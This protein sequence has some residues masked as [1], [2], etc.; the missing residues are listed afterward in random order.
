MVSEAFECQVIRWRGPSSP[1]TG[2]TRSCIRW[3]GLCKCTLAFR[4]KG[5][6]I[7][8]EF[9]SQLCLEK[10]LAILCIK[11]SL[12]AN[13]IWRISCQ[14]CVS[15]LLVD[16]HYFSRHLAFS[17]GGRYQ[18][19]LVDRNPRMLCS[20]L[21]VV[22]RSSLMISQHILKKIL[23]IPLIPSTPASRCTKVTNTGFNL[24]VAK[25]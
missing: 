7:R 19:N 6:K 22:V 2:C 10:I 9:V 11:F 17:K 18:L 24:F 5:V 8:G 1:C 14:Y 21:D 12:L 15:N 20:L 3:T 23:V 16:S 4:N 13:N 25:T